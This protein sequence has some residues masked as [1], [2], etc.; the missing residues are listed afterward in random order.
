MP[1]NLLVAN[2]V[3]CKIFAINSGVFGGKAGN[4]FYCVPDSGKWE[5]T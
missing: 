1:S 3:L 4:V 2:D 5:D